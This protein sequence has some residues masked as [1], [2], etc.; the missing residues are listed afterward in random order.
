LLHP[1]EE[2][3]VRQLVAA[4]G[5]PDSPRAVRKEKLE[6]VEVGNQK[7]ERSDGFSARAVGDG[8]PLFEVGDIEKMRREMESLKYQ[9]AQAQKNDDVGTIE[10]LQT[11]IHKLEKHG[12]AMTWDGKSK[13][14][15]DEVDR[16]RKAVTK[17]IS[18][19]LQRIEQENPKLWIHLD[20]S[21]EMGRFCVYKPRLRTNWMV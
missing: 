9:L 6:H 10:I 8:T 2:I 16:I 15:G 11:E 14:L 4:S 13:Q 3:D 17:C 21:L 7:R 5:V 20:E 1:G 19:S 12:L 18:T